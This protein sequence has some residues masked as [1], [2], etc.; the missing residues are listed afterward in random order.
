MAVTHLTLENRNEGPLDWDRLR[1]TV[2][3]HL[4]ELRI[5][6]LTKDGQPS[7]TP[8]V[9]PTD[10]KRFLQ[11]PKLERLRI[12]NLASTHKRIFE[13]EL[14]ELKVVDLWPAQLRKIKLVFKDENECAVVAENFDYKIKITH[15]AIR[16]DGEVA[17]LNR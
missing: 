14:E 7:K 4:K 1:R 2:G 5:I 8:C 11:F 10:V 15:V 17:V 16:A 3:S 13:R 6:G 9:N 12:E